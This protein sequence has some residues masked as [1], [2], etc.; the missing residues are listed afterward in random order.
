MLQMASTANRL[1]APVPVAHQES[2]STMDWTRTP[3]SL[4]PPSSTAY[5]AGILL[6][7]LLKTLKICQIRFGHQQQTLLISERHYTLPLL[8]NEIKI[9]QTWTLV[10]MCKH[11]IAL[12][13]YL[14]HFPKIVKRFI[15][16]HKRD[17]YR[18]YTG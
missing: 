17:P 5:L 16:I 6:R 14:Y 18:T 13:R 2:C 10:I 1:G 9:R 3:L 12:D 7:I 15:I 4:F 11:Y 8:P